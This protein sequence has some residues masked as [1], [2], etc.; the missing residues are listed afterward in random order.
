MALMEIMPVIRCD[1]AQNKRCS[2]VNLLIDNLEQPAEARLVE[3]VLYVW[4]ETR[5]G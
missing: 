4:A 1:S 5:D 3:Y 2:D